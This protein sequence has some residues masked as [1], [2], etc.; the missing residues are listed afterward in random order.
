MS[1]YYT[2]QEIAKLL[3]ITLRRLRNKIHAGNPL[4]PRIQPP[5]SRHRIW[6]KKEV[7]QWLHKYIVEEEKAYRKT[8]RER[9]GIY[10]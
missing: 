5:E 10:G 6:P 4:P 7:H 2:D 9:N 8:L 1:S 3:G